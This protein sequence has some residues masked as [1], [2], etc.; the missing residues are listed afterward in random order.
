MPWGNRTGPWGLGP[1]SGRA[2]GYCAGYPLP[3]YLN[4]AGGR[5]YW[6]GFGRGFR[7]FWGRGG[8]G[9]FF[10]WGVPFWGGAWPGPIAAPYPGEVESLKEQASYL[11][12]ALSEIKKRIGELESK[13]K[14][15]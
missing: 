13:P 8:R 12:N 5:G 14:E 9:R 4:P 10:A 3:G 1:M 6:P 7:S 15:E 11:E 2:M